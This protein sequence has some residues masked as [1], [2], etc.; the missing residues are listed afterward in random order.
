M[1]WLR[2]ILL[3]YLVFPLCLLLLECQ[4][5]EN[6]STVDPSRQSL[7]RTGLGA[8]GSLAVEVL[9]PERQ[10]KPVPV[11]SGCRPREASARSLWQV[12]RG[13]I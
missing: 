4:M 12:G 5:D 11:L 7:P 3:V 9:E 6:R 2:S 10:T 1:A 13:W 8:P